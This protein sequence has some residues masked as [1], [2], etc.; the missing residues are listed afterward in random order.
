MVPPFLISALDGGEW[1]ALR[2]GRCTFQK[3]SARY[4]LDR[5]LGIVLSISTFYKFHKVDVLASLDVKRR[6]VHTQLGPLDRADLNSW[7][8]KQVPD[9]RLYNR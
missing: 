1:S 5:R 7:R 3:R 2:P 4:P 6:S 8:T 9:I